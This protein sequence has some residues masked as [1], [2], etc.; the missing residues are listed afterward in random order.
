VVVGTADENFSPWLGVGRREIVL[1]GQLVDLVGR[2]RAEK[3]LGQ[4]A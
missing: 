1:L 4:L 2:K 3:S